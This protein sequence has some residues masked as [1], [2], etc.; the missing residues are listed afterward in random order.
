MAGEGAPIKIKAVAKLE[1]YDDNCTEK[2][3]N[4]GKAKPFEVLQSEDILVDP[5]REQLEKL[6]AM[7]VIIPKEAWEQ[8]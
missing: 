8:V 6:E 1:K 2:D 4:A 5:T 3:I 7:G